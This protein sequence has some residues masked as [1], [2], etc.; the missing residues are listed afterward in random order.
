[1]AK[2][3][4]TKPPLKFQYGCTKGH[5]GNRTLYYDSKS[6]SGTY[7]YMCYGCNTYYTSEQ[8]ERMGK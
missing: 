5:S 8:L 2:K 3:S 4:T 6:P 7:I 1:M